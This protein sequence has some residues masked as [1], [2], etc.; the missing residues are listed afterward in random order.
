ML[1]I[2]YNN[3]LWLH[4]VSLGTPPVFGEIGWIE[5]RGMLLRIGGQTGGWTDGFED[6]WMVAAIIWH[7]IVNACNIVCECVLYIHEAWWRCESWWRFGRVDDFQPEGHR[8]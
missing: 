6:E 5:M 4:C 7:V 8:L 2:S 1:V 3:R